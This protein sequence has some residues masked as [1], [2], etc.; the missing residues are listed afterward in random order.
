[1]K[2]FSDKKAYEEF[3]K[4][5]VLVSVGY[6]WSKGDK[7][8]DRIKPP[9]SLNIGTYTLDFHSDKFKGLLYEAV[10]SDGNSVLTEREAKAIYKVLSPHLSIDGK[11]LIA[12]I[13]LLK[14]RRVIE[15]K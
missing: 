1:M 4:Y 7:E 15:S 11:W 8:F 14:D 12:S 2:I 6:L 5:G 13:S 9:L 10:G 3:G